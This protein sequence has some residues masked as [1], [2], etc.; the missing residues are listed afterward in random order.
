MSMTSPS[1]SPF[2]LITSQPA[3]N[4]LVAEMWGVAGMVL[5]WAPV[6]L[7]ILLS[8]AGYN[9]PSLNITNATANITSDDDSTWAMAKISIGPS[10][11]CMY[12]DD[13]PRKCIRT[14]DFKPDPA[15]LHL[16][17]NQTLTTSLSQTLN[18]AF[19][20]NY[21]SAGCI[22]FATISLLVGFNDNSWSATSQNL[23]IWGS[24]F[25]WLSFWLNVA[26]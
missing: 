9:I 5:S 21:I 14:L 16:P 3:P 7:F 11:G 15:F 8:C 23:M 12:Y 19:V 25:A 6:I 10:G 17:V 1:G 26:I 24:L 13:S 2:D 4:P 20:T 18:R 22:G